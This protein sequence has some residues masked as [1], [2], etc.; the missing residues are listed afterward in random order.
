MIDDSILIDCGPD[1]Y[2]Q[3]SKTQCSALNSILIS[4][5]HPDH[6][7][8]LW[9][10]AKLYN[11]KPTIY[12]SRKNQ[13]AILK[14][15]NDLTFTFLLKEAKNFKDG[16]AMKIN[17]LN[18]TPFLVDHSTNTETYGFQ[19][20]QNKKSLVYISDFREIP[21][22]SKKFLKEATLVVLDGSHIKPAGPKHWGHM[23]IEKSIPLA[24]KLKA[25]QVYYTHIG[26]GAKSGTHQELENFV[27]KNGG[28]NFHI[29]YDG[30]ELTI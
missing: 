4:H 16:E 18:I 25:K 8:G 20:V 10:A 23:A 29:C 5:V 21:N 27:Q 9:D 14:R 11:Q 22:K 7:F 15:V 6:Y 2:R 26:H 24:K 30:L 19:I 12:L 17:N 28:K 13:K 3:F 1:F